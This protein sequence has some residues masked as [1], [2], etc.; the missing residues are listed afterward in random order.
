MAYKKKNKKTEVVINAAVVAVAKPIVVPP[1]VVTPPP[2]AT[3]EKAEKNSILRARAF[4]LELKTQYILF[5]KHMP[6]SVGIEKELYAKFPQ[7][8]KRIIN[9][10]LY[11]HTHNHRY[12]KK[13]QESTSRFNLEGTVASTVDTAAKQIAKDTLTGIQQKV[14]SKKAKK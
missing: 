1:T 14:K 9:T 2:K 12:L 6:L 8:S 3:T 10:A 7:Q 11:L 5:R 4:L 13:L